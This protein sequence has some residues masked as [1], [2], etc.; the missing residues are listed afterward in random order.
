MKT[1]DVAKRILEEMGGDPYEICSGSCTEFAK[2]LVD[3]V[4]GEIVNNLSEDMK[5]DL[6]GY[7]TIEPEQYI[8]KPSRR[9]M[10]AT[11]HCWI[12]VGGK[13]YDAFNPEG[14]EYESDLQFI[15]ENA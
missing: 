4:G 8:Q 13:F 5:D 7:E 12:K 9:N 10:W 1:S 3:E 2:R 15:E 6:D 14:V 11:S